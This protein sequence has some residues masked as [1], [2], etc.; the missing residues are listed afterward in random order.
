MRHACTCKFCQTP[1]T[2]SVDDDYAKLGDPYKI[3]K[4]ATCNFC[5][6]IRVERRRLDE[7]IARCCRNL[8]LL[9]EGESKARDKLKL[10]MEKLT[11]HYAE[12]VCRWHHAQGSMW[13]EEILNSILD[14]PLE[15]PHIIGRLWTMF[16]QWRDSQQPSAKE[17][18]LL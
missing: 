12:L 8:S 3:L 1:I 2:V 18:N 4:L 15:W 6:D 16:R 13:E 7:R 14:K 11:K 9:P 5:A 10:A 17:A